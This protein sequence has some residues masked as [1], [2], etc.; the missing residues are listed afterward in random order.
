M[1][2]LSPVLFAAAVLSAAV[3]APATAQDARI[4]YGDLDLST[5]AGA[6]A[7]DARVEEAG[8]RLCLE[9]RRMGRLAVNQSHCLTIVRQEALRELPRA[10]QTDYARSP[11]ADRQV[12]QVVDLFVLS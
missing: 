12:A 8:A 2:V 3:V 4:R 10:R 7:F 11:R 6:A 9:M 1:K 5:A